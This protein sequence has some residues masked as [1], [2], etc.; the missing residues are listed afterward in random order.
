MGAGDQVAV[1]WGWRDRAQEE[2]GGI[3]GLSGGGTY[4]MMNSWNQ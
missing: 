1:T 2:T 3:G 4:A